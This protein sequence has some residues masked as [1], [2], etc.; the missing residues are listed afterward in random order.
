[1]AQGVSGSFH[2]SALSFAPMWLELIGFSHSDTAVV[3]TIFWA[4]R[5]LGGLLGGKMGDAL[6]LRYPNAERIVL[7]QISSGSAVPLAAVL[8]R[9]LPDDPSTGVAYAAV[10]FVMGMF[11]S[12]N[13]PATNL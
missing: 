13:G 7:S 6:A 2:W 8:L 3:M 12:W 10:L 5:S 1:V 11:I 4:G 9:G